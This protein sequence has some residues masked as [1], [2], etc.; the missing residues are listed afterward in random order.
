MGGLSDPRLGTIDRNY[1]CQTCGEGQAECPGHYGHIDFARPVFHVGFLGKVKKL[2]ECVCVH[3]GKLKADPVGSI[4]RLATN[5]RFQI[6]FLRVCFRRHVQTTNVVSSVSGSI[7]RRYP[8][9]RQMR[10]RTKMSWVMRSRRSATVVAVV[11]SLQSAR[12]R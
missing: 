5:D 12:K 11:C 3:C 1:K 2:L 10:A 9:V 7:A 4:R 8:F 6:L